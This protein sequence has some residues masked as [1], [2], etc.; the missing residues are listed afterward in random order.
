MAETAET[1][2]RAPQPTAFDEVAGLV[3]APEVK[4][5]YDR[6]VAARGEQQAGLERKAAAVNPKLTAAQTATE[7][8]ARQIQESSSAASRRSPPGSAGSRRGTRRRDSPRSR[9]H[10][11]A[12]TKAT[13]SGPIVRSPTGRRRRI[14]R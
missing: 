9:A 2:T 1:P 12:G 4:T 13:R 14:R 7:D 5:A 11:R 6:V 8:F 10:S 3:F